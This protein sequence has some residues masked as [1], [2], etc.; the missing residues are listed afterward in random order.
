[1]KD[2]NKKTNINDSQDALDKKKS[3]SILLLALKRHKI[4]LLIILFLI[5]TTSTLCWFI[6]NTQVDMSIHAHVKS[7]NFGFDDTKNTFTVEIK[8]LYPGVEPQES[9][10]NL[11]NNGEMDGTISI[12]IASVTL[13]GEEQI[14]GEDYNVEYGE[15]GNTIYILGYPFDI[16]VVLGKNILIATEDNNKDSTKVDFKLEWDYDN[17]DDPSCIISEDD[18]EYNICDIEDTKMG[19]RSYIF[20]SNPD[21]ADKSS[22]VIDISVDIV[23]S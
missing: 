18:I 23:Q 1:M 5:L 10:L 2:I 12:G 22:L 20:S 11:V 16:Q 3:K 14:E 15:D 17:D 8:D 7:W 13:F 21:N 4:G 6:F 19:N 9:S